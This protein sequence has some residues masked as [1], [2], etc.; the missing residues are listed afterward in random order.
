MLDG[1]TMWIPAGW[2]WQQR[3]DGSYYAWREL[4]AP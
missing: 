3:D 1:A 2:R 4:A